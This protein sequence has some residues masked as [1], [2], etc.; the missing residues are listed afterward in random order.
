MTYEVGGTLS[1]TYDLYAVV[2]PKTVYLSN[3]RD[4]KPNKWKTTVTYVDEVGK[5]QTV[6][7]PDEVESDGIHVDTVKLGRVTL[8]VC[9]YGQQD[10][11]LNVHLRCYVTSR[12]TS[13]SREMFLDC[14]YLKPVSDEE[15]ALEAKERK[16]VQK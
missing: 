1:G 13:Y 5:T 11:T 6:M 2:L 12:Q 3:S 14:I 7:F 15:A 8:P 9:S 4:T 16:E 10:A